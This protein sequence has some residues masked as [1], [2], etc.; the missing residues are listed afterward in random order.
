MVKIDGSYVREL[1]AA[2]RDDAMIR[3][4]VSLCRELGVETVAEMVETSG[5]ED[6]LRRAGVDYAQGWLYGQASPEPTKPV[7][8]PSQVRPAL[9]RAG[10]TEQWG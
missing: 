8:I 2:G 6:I 3:H 7:P 5:V 4:L 1:T 9:R 10:V